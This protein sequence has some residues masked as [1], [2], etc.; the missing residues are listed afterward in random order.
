[1]IYS[2]LHHTKSVLNQR[3]C[4]RCSEW[5][6]LSYFSPNAQQCDMCW[7]DLRA[8]K[9]KR[10][11]GTYVILDEKECS[12]CHEILAV[13]K[14]PVDQFSKDR[15][16][17]VCARCLTAR[18]MASVRGLP[19]LDFSRQGIYDRDN[20]TCGMCGQELSKDSWAMDHIIP[21]SAQEPGH[22]GHVPWNV[23]VSC[24]SCNS[25]KHSKYGEAE[26]GLVR[27]LKKKYEEN[28]D[29]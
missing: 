5:W 1:V 7:N 23:R 29:G 27:Q 25:R 12:A 8:D 15:R 17:R 24:T 18:H 16:G 14:F 19:H 28:L 6:S 20:G 2:M 11:K 9:L 10:L 22:P 26:W 4:M 3:Q 21:V 13:R